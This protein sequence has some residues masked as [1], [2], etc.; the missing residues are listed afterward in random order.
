VSGVLGSFSKPIPARNIVH[1]PFVLSRQLIVR[2]AG[3]AFS[4]FLYLHIFRKVVGQWQKCSTTL[5]PGTV[6]ST[7][8]WWSPPTRSSVDGPSSGRK[9]SWGWSIPR[10]CV[11]RLAPLSKGRRVTR[12]VTASRLSFSF[13]F[14][15]SRNV[16]TA[17]IDGF[18]STTVSR[19]NR[20]MGNRRSVLKAS[21][22]RS[23]NLGIPLCFSA[24]FE[25]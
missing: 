5:S 24:S 8:G 11:R 1:G 2:A 21:W 7:H 20:H 19:V 12:K 22:H 10:V 6:I 16:T 14:S 4:S 13:P 15:F 18:P 23:G 9:V 17:V 3:P 25:F